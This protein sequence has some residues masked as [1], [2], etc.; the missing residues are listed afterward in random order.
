ME[1]A[2]APA[3]LLSHGVCL[4][5]RRAPC[6]RHACCPF[7]VALAAVTL[8]SLDMMAKGNPSR[9]NEIVKAPADEV[10]EMPDF[11]VYTA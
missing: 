7:L 10:H 1:S 8:S 3:A 5:P 11:A 6:S 2:P 9:V 4:G